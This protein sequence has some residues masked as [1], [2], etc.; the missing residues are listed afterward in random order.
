MIPLA[1]D[2]LMSFPKTQYVVVYDLMSD[3][4]GTPKI[5]P[6][7]FFSEILKYS[8][9]RIIFSFTQATMRIHLCKKHG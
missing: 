3:W 9:R 6:H 8:R 5:K 4:L 7:H 1:Y 2:T